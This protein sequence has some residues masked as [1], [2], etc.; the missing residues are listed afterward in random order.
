MGA[1]GEACRTASI[2]EK[3]EVLQLAGE[4]GSSPC[5]HPCEER[6]LE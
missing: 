4:P 1:D 3:A 2:V 5:P 6:L